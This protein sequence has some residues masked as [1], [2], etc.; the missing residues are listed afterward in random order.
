MAPTATSTIHGHQCAT[1]ATTRG[2]GGLLAVHGVQP[3][4][5]GRELAWGRTLT[6]VPCIFYFRNLVYAFIC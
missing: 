5:L 3:R 6:E 4:T 2:A 1:E